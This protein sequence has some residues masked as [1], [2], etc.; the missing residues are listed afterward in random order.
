MSLRTGHILLALSAL[1]WV[2]CLKEARRIPRDKMVDVCTEMFFMDQKIRYDQDLRSKV[3][4]V[5]FYEGIFEKYGY[6]IDDY[7]YSVKYYLEDP[8][9]MAKIMADVGENL[10]KQVKE[11]DVLIEQE[12]WKNAMM[13]IYNKPVSNLQPRPFLAEEHY[14]VIKDS[15]GNGF[16]TFRQDKGLELDT[17]VLNPE[18]IKP[19]TAA[20]QKADTLKPRPDVKHIL[21]RS[22]FNRLQ[23][24]E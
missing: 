13:E 3:D 24:V 7:L 5:L 14:R 9:R 15:T 11:L 23:V 10:E 8:E 2:S 6:T 12:D 19:D 18:A 22:E 21:D 17:L 20:V 1:L 16:F 4:T